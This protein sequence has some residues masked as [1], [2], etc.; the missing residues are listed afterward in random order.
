M[1]FTIPQPLQHE[2]EALHERL[3]QATRAGGEVG[4]AAK[5]LARVAK[6]VAPLPRVE[7]GEAHGAPQFQIEGK[8]LGEVSL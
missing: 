4:E 2:H 5:T 1:K 8:P 3:S 7:R 6:I